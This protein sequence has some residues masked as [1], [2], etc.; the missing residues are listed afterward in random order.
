MVSGREHH[1]W[2]CCV[3]CVL[4]AVS[5][6]YGT[7]SGVT[8]PCR[9]ETVCSSVNLLTIRKGC[10]HTLYDSVTQHFDGDRE[11]RA[12]GSAAERPV[13]DF[14]NFVVVLKCKSSSVLP[15][16]EMCSA[17]PIVRLRAI[18]VAFLAGVIIPWCCP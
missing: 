7:I 4:P 9:A 15:E 8:I 2:T 6:D 11:K 3:T 14:C 17:L 12:S 1:A 5:D 10:Y 13:N 18:Y 16:S